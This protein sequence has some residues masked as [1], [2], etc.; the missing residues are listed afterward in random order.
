MEEGVRDDRGPGV[1]GSHLHELRDHLGPEDAAVG[2]AQ[3]DGPVAVV[4]G[5]AGFH[6]HVELT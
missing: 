3:L 6:A 5:L 2:V 1:R 4:G